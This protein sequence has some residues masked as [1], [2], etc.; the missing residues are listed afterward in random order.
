MARYQV[1]LAYD[2]THFLGFQRQGKSRT[3][4]VVVEA[5]LRQ[6]GW[7]GKTL[8]AAG[9]TDTGVHASGQVIA[10]DLDW[11]HDLAALGRAMNA[12][13]PQ[14]VAVQLVAVAADDFHPRFDARS[15]TYQY[16]VYCEPNRS[17][18]HDRF[19]WRVWPAAA[20][21]KLQVAASLFEGTYDFA[22]FGT[23][24]RVNGSTIRTVYRAN[25]ERLSGGLLFE[26]TANA[27]LY[28]MV[29]RIVFLQVLAGQGHLDLAE[30]KLGI[31]AAQ[32]QTPGL[33]PP[34]GLALTKVNYAASEQELNG[35]RI[36]ASGEDDRGKDLRH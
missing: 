29:R 15:R 21:E 1:T 2:G 26:I 13:L 27:Y 7:Q 10:F 18:L 34:Q 28:H 8:L 16:R 9:R 17:P 11:T 32:P 20:L 24:P 25:W 5:A 22:A 35:F 14:D 31:E 36:I 19:A 33:A 12:N 23:P 6:L 3:V 30:L 4:Q